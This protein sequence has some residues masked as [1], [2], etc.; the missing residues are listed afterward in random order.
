MPDAVWPNLFV[1]G[2]PKAGTT[3]LWRYLGEHPDIFMSPEKEPG[4][5]SSRR[6][7][8]SGDG[9]QAYLDLFAQA[10]DEPLRGEASP[11]YLS[12]KR[13][14]GAIHS[15]SPGARIVIS[16]R[17]PVERTQSSFLSLVS[18]GVE[19]RTFAQAIA[20]DLAGRRVPGRPLYVKPKLYSPGVARYLETFGDQVHVLFFE[21][22]V[23]DPAATMR[24]LYRFLGVDDEFA[25]SLQPKPHNQFRV[26]RTRTVKRLRRARRVARTLVPERVHERIAAATTRPADKPE[27]DQESV[28]ALREAYRPDVMALRKLLGPRLPKA[29]ERQFP[30]D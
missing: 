2:A 30:T 25:A 8:A 1:V 15:V 18:D 20:D 22:L 10:G 21:H 4:F 29:W 14:P 27:P 7:L 28:Q 3:S 13:A 19:E 5:F 9:A 11:T 6:A 24:E 17:E 16:L 23:R 26:P 12:R